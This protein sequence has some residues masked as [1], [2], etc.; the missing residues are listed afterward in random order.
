M[1]RFVLSACDFLVFSKWQYLFL[2]ILGHPRLHSSLKKKVI[3]WERTPAVS[4][5]G[6]V[7]GD[8]G[9]NKH[10]RI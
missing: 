3:A 8:A 7:W 1:A 6:I 5:Y 2:V 9:Q 4:T 10:G